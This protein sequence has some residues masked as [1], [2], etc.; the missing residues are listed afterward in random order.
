MPIMSEMVRIGSLA[1]HSVTKSISSPSRSLSISRSTISAAL[2]WIW[3]SMRR[4][5]FGVNAAL[6]NRRYKVC[7]GGSMARK[8]LVACWISA[9]RGSTLMP[10]AELKMSVCWLTYLTSAWRVMAQYPVSECGKTDETG[11]CQDSPSAARSAANVWSRVAKSAVQKSGAEM[12]SGWYGR[13]DSGRLST[14]MI[15]AVALPEG[16]SNG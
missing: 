13:G 14:V 4:T 1:E 2:A 16:L 12:S 3:A 8:K 15:C 5:C 6:I 7:S 10:S 9:G 11:A